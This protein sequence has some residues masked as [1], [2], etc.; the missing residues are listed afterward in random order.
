MAEF[1][2]REALIIK[3]GDHLIVRTDRGITPA[4]AAELR[5]QLL[6]KLPALADATVVAA[7]GLY[8]LRDE[9]RPVVSFPGDMTEAEAD[10]F[11]RRWRDDSRGGR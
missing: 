5:Q 11:K 2:V 1:P 7:D 3:P 6:T 4:E 10:E 8:V 9:A